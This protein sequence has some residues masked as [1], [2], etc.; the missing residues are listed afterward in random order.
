MALGLF[1]SPKVITLTHIRKID[2]VYRVLTQCKLKM[3][4]TSEIFL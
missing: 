2:T 3:Y 1:D 4:W